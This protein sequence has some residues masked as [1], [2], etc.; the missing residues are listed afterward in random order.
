MLLNYLVHLLLIFEGL[1]FL[2]GLQFL[3]VSGISKHLLGVGFPLELELGLAFLCEL[4]D[5]LFLRVLDVTLVFSDRL[6]RRFLGC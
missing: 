1:L 2:L 5:F 6:E 3:I 4:S